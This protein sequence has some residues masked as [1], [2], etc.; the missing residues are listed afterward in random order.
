MAETAIS[1]L[2]GPM[3]KSRSNNNLTGKQAVM[4]GRILNRLELRKQ[5]DQA[6]QG[7][8]GV[9][10][11]AATVAP[12]KRAVKQKAGAAAKVRKPRKSKSP[13]RMQAMWGI[14]DGGM[15]EVA[16]FN[17]NQRVAAEAKLSALLGK[18]KGTYFLQ[19][20]KQPMPGVEAA[21]ESGTD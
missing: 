4:A 2:S 15:K 6:A 11:T 12:T 19:I 5:T 7:E 3:A 20:V 9:F 1:Y 21:E 13:P 17:Y 18:Q 16:R 14:Y 8:A 10:D